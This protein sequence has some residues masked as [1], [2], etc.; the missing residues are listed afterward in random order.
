MCPVSAPPITDGALLVGADGRIAAVGPRQAVHAPAGAEVVELGEAALLPGLVNVHAHPELALFRGALEDL[1]FPE[2]IR[3]LVSARWPHPHPEDDLLAARWSTVEALR[4]GITTLGATESSGAALPALREA[5]MR[6]IV[7]REVFGPAPE[8]A[9]A[10]LAELR[11]AVE[12][13]RRGETERVRVGISPHAPYTVSD[14]LFSAT[15]AWAREEHLPLA[16]HAAESREERALVTRGAGPFAAGLAARGIATPPRGRSTVQMLDR[17]GVLSARTLLV[18]CVEVDAEDAARIAASGSTVA[19]CPVANAKLGHRVAPYP[20][21]CDAGVPVG[22]GTDSVG[23]NNRLDLLEEARFAALIHRAAAGR[24]DV[25]PADELLRLCTL[26]A[27]RALGLDA[28]VGTLEVGKDADLCAVSLAA[29]H[30]RPVHEPVAALFHSARGSDVVLTAVAGRILYRNGAVHS[31]DVDGLREQVNA[32]A[33][34]LRQA[35][36]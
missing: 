19:H 18:H 20:L 33:G 28:R 8:Q 17:L 14:A 16:V 11:R 7:F 6:G 27:A 5:G 13:L 32:A 21:L 26:G 10:S 9:A 15:A 25:L 24:P 23:S 2:W 4:A 1:P 36:A 31:V 3:R 34:R 30:V 22:L 35:L 29:P 12:E